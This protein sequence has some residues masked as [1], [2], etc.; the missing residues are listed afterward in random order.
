MISVEQ[1]KQHIKA[2]SLVLKDQKLPLS[3]ALGR[4][5]AE[6]I[7]ASFDQPRFNN[8]AMDGFAVKH[9]S[10]RS[11]SPESPVR[12][13]VAGEIAA[14]D[15]ASYH[16]CDGCCIPIMT[17]GR[18]PEGADAVIRVEDTS[19]FNHN[20]EVMFFAAVKPGANIRLKGEELRKD[21]VVIEKGTLITP[22]EIGVLATFGR[23]EVNVAKPPG[24]AIISTGS[25]L[26]EPGESLKPGEI[27]NSN[28]SVLSSLAACVG[29]TLE[30]T[31]A[32]RDIARD[33]KATLNQAFSSADI[34]VTTGGISE[35]KYDLVESILQDLGVQKCFAKV[36]QKPGLPLY[37][38]TKPN[39]LVFG[40]PGN[41]VS[42][43]ITFLIYVAPAI[44]EALGLKPEPKLQATLA[45]PFK[46]DKKKHRFLFGHIY[47]Q[48]GKLMAKPSEKLGSHMLSSALGKNAILESPA[49]NEPLEAGSAITATQLPWLKPF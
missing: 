30:F 11:A 48:D 7:N 1:A 4:V 49:G 10:L 6:S 12:L 21:D 28:L 35:G 39:Q 9:E 36:A 40:L 43:F 37:F 20:G 29:G 46:R 19:G 17:G 13:T 22:A 3:D 26:S 44:H 27:Y 16:L 47:E 42:A 8:S 15:S 31:A 18:M 24:I 5:L 41:P 14:G 23:A 2:S 45:K 38:G 33:L 25:E 32:V 34:V